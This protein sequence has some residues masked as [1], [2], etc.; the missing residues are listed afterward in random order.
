MG[1]GF[2]SNDRAAFWPTIATIAALA[3]DGMLIV[4]APPEPYLLPLQ[5]PADKARIA[6]SAGRRRMPAASYASQMPG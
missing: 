2:G 1:A 3:E 4:P 6:P 5:P